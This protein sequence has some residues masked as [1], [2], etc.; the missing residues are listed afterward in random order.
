MTKQ[1]GCGVPMLGKMVQVF[2]KINFEKIPKIEEEE[3]ESYEKLKVLVEDKKGKVL[4]RI[5]NDDAFRMG[6]LAAKCHL[7]NIRDYIKKADTKRF[8][9]DYIFYFLR[10]IEFGENKSALVLSNNPLDQNVFYKAGYAEVIDSFFGE[11]IVK[12]SH[13]P[14]SYTVRFEVFN[15]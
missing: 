12:N 9:I 4:S 3:R 7:S 10:L 6:K 13:P 15:T 8:C 5:S 14:Y 11:P 1:A 2:K